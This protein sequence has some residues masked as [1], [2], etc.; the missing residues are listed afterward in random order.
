M[1]DAKD[2]RHGQAAPGSTS[3]TREENHQKQEQQ[4]VVMTPNPQTLSNRGSLED[5]NGVGSAQEKEVK[6]EVKGERRQEEE[7]EVEAHDDDD[8]DDDHR[9]APSLTLTRSAVRVPRLKRRGFLAQVTVIPEV[10]QPQDY[11]NQVKWT[12]TT[13]VS[14]SGALAPLGSAIFYRECSAHGPPR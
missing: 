3:L 13:I 8:D 9:S 10:E 7:E 12:V 5:T 14:L 2:S 1:E 4:Q 6:A 11:R